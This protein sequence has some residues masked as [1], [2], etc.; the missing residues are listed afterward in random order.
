VISQVETHAA[1]HSLA[2]FVGELQTLTCGSDP[3]ITF[4]RIMLTRTQGYFKSLETRPE[5]P[6][7]ACALFLAGILTYVAL[8][9]PA[10][11]RNALIACLGTLDPW[12]APDAD[13]VKIIASLVPEAIV[14]PS[15]ELSAQLERFV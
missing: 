5:V 1:P 13:A 4:Q 14:T 11:L 3:K 6:R 10:P 2:K 9:N 8:G 15:V 7:R 12:A